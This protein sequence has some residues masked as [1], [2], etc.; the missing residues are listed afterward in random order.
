VA[1]NT[2]APVWVSR[3]RRLMQEGV[4]VTAV[5]FMENEAL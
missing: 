4:G 5:Q 2:A 1:A 3:V